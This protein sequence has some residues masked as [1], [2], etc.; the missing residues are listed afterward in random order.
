MTVYAGNSPR[1]RAA[2]TGAIRERGSLNS[3]AGVMV[4][5][6]TPG[7][8]E[9]MVVISPEVLLHIREEGWS[10]QEVKNYLFEATKREY[11]FWDTIL[12]PAWAPTIGSHADTDIASVVSSPDDLIVLVAGGTAG[13][14]FCT[15]LPWAGETETKSI[16]RQIPGM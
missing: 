1:S 15:I 6:G 2:T 9:M 7:V 10:K 5:N 8:G 12:D 11:S 4:A 16:T 14:F 13:G 3:I